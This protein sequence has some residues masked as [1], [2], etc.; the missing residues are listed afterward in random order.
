MRQRVQKIKKMAKDVLA[1]DD[2]AIKIAGV[3]GKGTPKATTPAKRKSAS[4]SEDDETATPSKKPASA[5]RVSATPKGRGKKVKE[6]I[7]EE[8]EDIEEVEKT[9]EDAGGIKKSV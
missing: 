3:N 1:G 6:E 7:V 2:S 4:A 9:D 5:K 8:N